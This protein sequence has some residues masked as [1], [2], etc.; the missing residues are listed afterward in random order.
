MMIERQLLLAL[1]LLQEPQAAAPL[2]GVQR[3]SAEA[4]TL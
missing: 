4:P 3:K 2:D 1:L